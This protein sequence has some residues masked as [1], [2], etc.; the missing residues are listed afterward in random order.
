MKPSYSDSQFMK[1]AIQLAEEKMMAGEGGPFGAVITQHGNIVGQG[2]NRVLSTN[3]PTAHAEIVAI[4]NSCFHLQTFNLEGCVL[5][6]SCEPCPMCLAAVYWS[7]INRVVYGASRHDAEAIGFRDN[8]I[9]EQLRL[10][11][12]ERSIDMVQ[13]LKQESLASFKIWK[14]LEDKIEY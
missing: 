9:Y 11:N 1:I 3:D 7:G 4:R 8:H 5:Y 2:W 10:D 14:E 6:A 13:I 12:R